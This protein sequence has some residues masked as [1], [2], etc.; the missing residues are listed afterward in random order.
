MHVFQQPTARRILFAS[1]HWYLDRSNGASITTR[2]TLLAL[3][4]RGWDVK[5]FCGAATDF[6]TPPSVDE[7]LTSSGVAVKKRF[8]G[9]V[10]EGAFQAVAYRDS[11]VESVVV[12][13]RSASGVGVG[14]VPSRPA[15]AA[16]LQLF[17]ETLRRL[18]PDVVLTY[19]GYWLGGDMLKLAKKSGAKTVAWI[20][21]F[22]YRDAGYFR[23][24]DLT[25]VPSEFAADVYRKRLGLDPVAVPPLIDWRK[26][27][28]E[29]AEE[30]DAARKFVLFVNPTSNK[31]A[32]LFAK[33]VEETNKIRPDIP[34]L[35]V[36]GSAASSALARCDWAR[37]DGWNL[38]RAAN[39]S[40]PRE[41]YRVARLA[42]IPSFFEESFGRVAAEA[43]G[44]GVPVVASSRGAL[45]ETVGDAGILLDVPER[46]T[47][48][49]QEK[50][51]AADAAPWVDAILALWDDVEHRKALREN[52]LQRA[53]RWTEERVVALY[54][55]ALR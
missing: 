7:I 48:T 18:S 4:R 14:T 35:V 31:G 8:D 2:E 38:F 42:L 29:S 43:L 1:W 19:G 51:T 5:T 34:F 23:D 27:R 44:A 52:G 20:H 17:A 39:T 47:P 24:V 11:G 54:A 12:A 6:F 26:V 10:G 25:L 53:E 16:F 36:E 46:L 21:N 32:P 28:P 15:G 13:P 30:D 22:A 50:P 9:G 3:A 37:R 45:P 41:F 40:T 55:A 33:I 49:S